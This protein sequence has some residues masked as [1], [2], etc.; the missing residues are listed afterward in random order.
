MRL[1]EHERSEFR[2]NPERASAL[3]SSLGCA[4]SEAGGCDPVEVAAWT[5][6]ANAL[7]NLDETLTRG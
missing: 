1:L 3:A 2:A 4:C 5:L 6:L 7:L